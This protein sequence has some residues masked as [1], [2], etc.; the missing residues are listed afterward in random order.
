M[1]P[2]Y[3]IEDRKVSFPGTDAFAVPRRPYERDDLTNVIEIVD[4]PRRQQLLECHLAEFGMHCPL[5]QAV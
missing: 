1:R 2:F 3:L 4:D 5:T